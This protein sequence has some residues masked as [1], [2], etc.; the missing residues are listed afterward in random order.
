[1][2]QRS[3]QELFAIYKGGKSNADDTS[4]WWS[5]SDTNVEVEEQIDHIIR[6]N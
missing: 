5:S 2:S 3:V 4:S 1:M 6:S